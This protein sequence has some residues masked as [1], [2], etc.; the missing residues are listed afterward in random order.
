MRPTKRAQDERKVSELVSVL[1]NEKRHTATVFANGCHAT[2]WGF[3]VG[4]Y[5]RG[6]TT[7]RK[8]NLTSPSGDEWQDTLTGIADVMRAEWL[9]RVL[10]HEMQ[11]VRT[12]KAWR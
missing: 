9:P 7:R 12:R 2:G 6:S 1:R 8:Y 10:L 4:P 11:Q 5:D 3:T